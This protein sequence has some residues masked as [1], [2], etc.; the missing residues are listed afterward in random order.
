[1]SMI[2]AGP[3]KILTPAAHTWYMHQWARSVSVLVMAYCLFNTKPLADTKPTYCHS[4]AQE[5]I[6]WILSQNFS[7]KML[8]KLSFVPLPS[9]LSVTSTQ[10]ISYWGR[11]LGLHPAN[12]RW[13]YFVTTSLIGWAQTYNQPWHSV[14]AKCWAFSSEPNLPGFTALNLQ[15]PAIPGVR[16]VADFSSTAEIGS[17]MGSTCL[18]DVWLDCSLKTQ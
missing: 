1:M 16:L 13:R 10:M 17:P 7:T 3:F 8:L 18:M 12:E 2:K 15:Y 14:A 5:I 6:Q 4:D 11:I 9:Y